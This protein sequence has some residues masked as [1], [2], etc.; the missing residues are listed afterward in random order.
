MIKIL[1]GEVLRD[2]D[3]SELKYQKN[4]GSVADLTIGKAITKI[5]SAPSAA[6]S[7]QHKLFLLSTRFYSENEMEI[8]EADYQLVF[9][10]T[11]TSKVFGSIVNGQVI[12]FLLKFKSVVP[13]QKK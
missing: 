12:D 10:L 5:L 1:N 9:D 6:N 2:F 7:D 8:D 11:K 13:A 3:G 4:D